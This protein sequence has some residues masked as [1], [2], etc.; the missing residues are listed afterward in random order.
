MDRYKMID[1]STLGAKEVIREEA[2]S[3]YDKGMEFFY[4]QLVHLNTTIFIAD[5]ILKVP[6]RFFV[7]PDKTIFFNVVLRNF[8][9]AG[10][11]VITRLATDQGDDLYTLS[12]FKNRVRELVRPEYASSFDGKL[13]K[14]RFDK[15][16]VDLFKRA[17]DLRNERVGHISQEV[18][19]GEIEGTH[20]NFSELKSLRDALNSL[21]EALS[22]NADHMMLPISYDPRVQHPRGSNHKPDIEELLDYLISTSFLLNVPEQNPILWEHWRDGLTGTDVEQINFYRKKYGLPSV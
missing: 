2:F 5:Q 13:K 1:F 16:T 18:A 12:H 22:F 8:F 11:L 17:R 4:L 21:L 15:R 3:E 14:Y 19:L 7:A 9:D 20:L 10:L 6:L